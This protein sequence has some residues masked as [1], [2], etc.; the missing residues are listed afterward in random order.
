VREFSSVA[1]PRS[2]LRVVYF[3]VGGTLVRVEPSV[4][5]VYARAAAEYGFSLE[6]AALQTRFREAWRE[7]VARSRLRGFVCSDAI[8]REE[9]FRIVCQAFAGAVPSECMPALFDDLYERFVSSRA[10]TVVPGA[11]AALERLR[12]LGLRLGILSNWDS[13]LEPTLEGLELRHL[14]DYFVASHSV[15]REKPHTAMFEHALGI[16]G[17]P[18]ARVLHV[19]DSLEA[20]ILPARR[21]GFRTLWLLNGEPEP[22]AE[23]G[24]TAGPVARGLD[25]LTERDWEALLV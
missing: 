4:G 3:D 16:C 21:L 17:E 24:L 25:T 11:R 23:A 1:R 9:W 20:D 14:F 12:A 18:A 19:G 10:W 22:S 2:P 7:S 8:L 5:E 15:G 13:R 6:P